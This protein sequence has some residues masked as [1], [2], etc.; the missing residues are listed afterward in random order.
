MYNRAIGEDGEFD[1]LK[2]AHDKGVAIVNMKAFNGN[3]MVPTSKII[4]GIVNISYADMLR[5]CLSNGNISTVDAGAKYPHEFEDDVKASLLP[6][7]TEEERA[8]LKAEADKVSGLFSSICRECMHC[9][10]AFECPQGINF[11]AILGT[12]A[13]YSIAGSLGKENGIYRE[14]YVAI[15]G[16]LADQCIACGMCKEQCEYHLDIPAMMAKAASDLG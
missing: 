6:G 15:E 10:E 11:P 5:F 12:H 2:Y 7:M 14:Q 13:R 3:G 8:A 1:Y 16:P 9:L 4:E